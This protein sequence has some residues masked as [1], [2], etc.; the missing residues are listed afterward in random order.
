MRYSLQVFVLAAMASAILVACGPTPEQKR[1]D[2]WT[3]CAADVQTLD[4][5]PMGPN[6]VFWNKADEC[7]RRN[8]Y[9]FTDTCRETFDSD[10]AWETEQ[11]AICYEHI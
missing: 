11:E 2:T 8:G 5:I 6:N 7:M 10:S 3:G 4:S 9:K 1:T